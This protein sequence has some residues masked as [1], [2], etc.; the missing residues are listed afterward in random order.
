[1]DQPERAADQPEPTPALAP[2]ARR[3]GRLRRTPAGAHVPAAAGVQPARP[4]DRST[5]PDRAAE[6]RLRRRGVREP[7][8]V[9]DAPGPQP[10]RAVGAA[11]AGAWWLRGRRL[12][13]G[14]ERVARASAARPRRAA[15]RGL[16]RPLP[17]ARRARRRPVRDAVREPRRRGRRHAAP[18]ARPDLRLPGRPPATAP[19]PTRHPHLTPP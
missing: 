2:A 17:R 1:A 6:G 15:A 11:P 16:G 19:P 18:P 5:P 13:A 14:P 8:S 10:T 7:V 4:D 12:H 3:V 9:P